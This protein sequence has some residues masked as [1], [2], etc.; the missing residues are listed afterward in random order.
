MKSDQLVSLVVPIYNVSKYLRRC[1]DSIKRQ[2]YQNI[3]VIMVNDGSTDKSATIAN[4]YATSDPRFALFEKEN[5]GLSSARNFGMKYANGSF[6][7][8]IDSDDFISE[9]YVETLLSAFNDDLDVVVADYVIFSE[10]DGKFYRH[11][12]KIENRIYASLE[13][14]KTLAKNLFKPGSIIMPVWKNMYRLS[15]LNNNDIKYVSERLIYTED[16]LFNL[17]CYLRA[18]KVATI[19]Q[20]LFFHLVVKTSLSQTYRKNYYEMQKEL[21]GKTLSLLERIGDEELITM[22]RDSR[23]DALAGSFLKLSN[24]PFPEAISNIKK[25]LSDHESA[26]LLSNSVSKVKV[27]RRKPIFLI[28]KTKRPFLITIIC[29][30]MI[31]LEPI[32]R[33]TQ[34]MDVYTISN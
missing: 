29:K 1:L 31:Y 22:Y 24:C 3:E 32:Y 26:E 4:E 15:F 28:A 13:E 18:R 34:K 8:F 6:I 17:E 12:G 27:S 19:N 14:K 11:N 25:V 5:G 23:A 9:K 10:E 21:Y 7:S 2:T 16:L 30:A 20:V 33:K